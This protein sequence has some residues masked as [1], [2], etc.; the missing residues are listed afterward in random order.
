[1]TM[2][3]M[4]L[5][6]LTALS[7]DAA[8]A[9]GQAPVKRIERTEITLAADGSTV[10]R[11]RLEFEVREAAGVAMAAEQSLTVVEELGTLDVDEAYVIKADGRRVDLD[12]ASI[13]TREAPAGPASFYQRGVK[14]RLVAFREVGVGDRVV[15]AFTRRQRHDGFPG[16][17]ALL[18]LFST[19]LPAAADAEITLR[20]PASRPLRIALREVTHQSETAG[21]IM[22]HRFAHRHEGVRAIEPMLPDAL[23]TEPMLAVSTFASYEAIGAVIAREMWAKARPTEDIARL[24]GDIVKGATDKRAEAAAIDQW[25]KRNIR[26]AAVRAPG[27]RLPLSTAGEVASR[28]FASTEDMAI[29]MTALCTAR[30]IA[31]EPALVEAGASFEWPEAPVPGA[32]DHALVHLVDLD[33]FTDP[34]AFLSGFGVLSVQTADK[35]ILLLGESG[36]RRARTPVLRAAD[37]L[38]KNE[39]RITLAGDGSLTSENVTSATGTF[40]TELRSTALRIRG[41]G[42]AN[43]ALERLQALKIDGEAHYDLGDPRG[44]EPFRLTTRLV[45]RGL[46]DLGAREPQRLMRALFVADRPGYGR[47]PRL[48][49]E[50]G[51]PFLCFPAHQVE[52][53]DIALPPGM[54]VL[55]LPRGQTLRLP[56]GRYSSTFAVTGAHILVTRDLVLE[57][58]HH[59]CPASDVEATLATQRRIAA[60]ANRRFRLVGNVA[61]QAAAE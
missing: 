16:E 41:R 44:P 14:T 10:T 61:G 34:A 20:A 39:I 57:P 37:N 18:D 24:A 5:I 33:L 47:V 50:R 17:F 52:T 26:I 7:I 28:R 31:A 25:M 2:R 8:R 60:D 23:D 9:D 59:V 40:E 58:K 43:Y 12:R 56:F 11:T 49:A 29:L 22:V 6:L 55:D 13:A 54:R 30:G 4:A 21:D 53:V 27:V 19:R 35:P 38:L 46:V 15:L 1:M 32:V 3:C 48:A 42:E 45:A 51:A 36:V